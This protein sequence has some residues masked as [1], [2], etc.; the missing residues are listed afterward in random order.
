MF[1]SIIYMFRATSWSSSG[2]SIVSMQRLV[3]VTR[4][5]WPS[6]MQ[7]IKKN[8]GRDWDCKSTEDDAVLQLFKWDEFYYTVSIFI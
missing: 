7:V 3:Y 6:G 1:I 5:K 4:C 8:S 2:E